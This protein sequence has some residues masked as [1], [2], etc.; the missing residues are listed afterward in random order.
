MEK[1][2]I[3]SPQRITRKRIESIKFKT[4]Y[5]ALRTSSSAFIKRKDVRKIIFS[6]DGYKCCYCGRSDHLSVD[7][8]TSVY[9]AA[10]GLFPIDLLNT[11]ENLQTLCCYCNERKAP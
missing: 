1:F 10:K 8:I 2:P 3:W 11:K 5:Q 9:K 6:R 7:H 4:R